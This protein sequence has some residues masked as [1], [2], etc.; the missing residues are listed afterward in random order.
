MRKSLRFQQGTRS[1]VVPKKL[2]PEM[3][4]DARHILLSVF[5]IE[6]CWAYAMQLRAEANSEPRKKFHMMSRLRKAAKNAHV[7]NELMNSV[8]CCGAQTKLEL[9]AYINW[10]NGL[11]LFEQQEWTK[12]K[13]LL[14]SV[15][16][17]YNGLSTSLDED[18]RETYTSRIT[19]ILPQIRYCAYNIGDTSAASD[20]RDL[21]AGAEGTLAEEQLDDLLK[22]MQALQAGSVTEVTWLGTTIPVKLNKARVAVLANQVTVFYL[23]FYLNFNNLSNLNYV[24]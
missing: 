12:A 15:Q 6:R 9:T 8:N 16:Q 20:L 22:Q 19:E 24:S 14:E 4:T 2:T 1:R 7:L 5:E 17:I 23:R 11:V 13:E 18:L 21:R 10:I 3:I